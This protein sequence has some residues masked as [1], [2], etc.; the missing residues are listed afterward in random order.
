[1]RS[2]LISFFSTKSVTEQIIQNSLSEN[3]VFLYFYLIMVFDAFNFSLNGISFADTKLTISSL[4]FLWGYFLFTAIGIIL[5]YFVNGGLKGHHFI[6]KFFSFSV[7]VGIKYEIAAEIIGR[8]PELF[9]FLKIPHY[10]LIT[11]WWLDLV[12]L[13][14]IAY[15]IYKTR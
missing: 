4:I 6:N 10:G 11:W 1:M 3:Q 14:N 9:P 13:G 8:L 7:T 2:K 15:R 5:L 12:M